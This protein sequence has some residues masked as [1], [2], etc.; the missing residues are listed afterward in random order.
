MLALKLYSTIHWRISSHASRHWS[1]RHSFVLN[2]CG[3]G[4]E[5]LAHLET[6]TSYTC[7]PIKKRLS[8]Y[9]GMPE[10][11]I[12]G[13]DGYKG[14]SERRIGEISAEIIGLVQGLKLQ[15]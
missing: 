4:Y 11:V 14:R 5:K 3:S 6:L 2:T 9:W 15:I 10:L 7:E 8:V 13:F 12:D 1:R